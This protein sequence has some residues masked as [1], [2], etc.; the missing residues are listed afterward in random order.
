M[1]SALSCELAADSALEPPFIAS[2][3]KGC[4][5]LQGPVQE[6]NG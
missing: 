3:D 1:R 6:D 4:L 2:D 5:P